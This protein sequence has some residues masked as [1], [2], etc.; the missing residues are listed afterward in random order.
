MISLKV[1]YCYYILA[2]PVVKPYHIVRT[3]SPSVPLYFLQ[4]L[5]FPDSQKHT[6]A[7]LIAQTR[8]IKNKQLKQE[9]ENPKEK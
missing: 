8:K 6:G 9:T 7:Q 2:L 4:K 1:Q 5:P 3:Q